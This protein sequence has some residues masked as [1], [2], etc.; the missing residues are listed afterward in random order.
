[1]TLE[2]PNPFIKLQHQCRTGGYNGLETPSL[3]ETLVLERFLNIEY[4]IEFTCAWCNNLVVVIS[5][6]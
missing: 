4:F 3:L 2:L 5:Q 1:M 6:H